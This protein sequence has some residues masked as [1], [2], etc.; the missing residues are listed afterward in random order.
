MLE[1]SL[2]V[3]GLFLLTV[4]VIEDFVGAQT[5]EDAVNLHTFL[6]NT[7]AYNKRVR[8]VR[9]QTHPVQVKSKYFKEFWLQKSIGD[10][11]MSVR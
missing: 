9:N 6:F 10:N 4:I 11:G 5:G 2:R 1:T 8:P 7:T 3:T